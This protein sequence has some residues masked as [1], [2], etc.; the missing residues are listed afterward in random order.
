MKHEESIRSMATQHVPKLPVDQ[1]RFRRNLQVTKSARQ[2]FHQ[3][4]EMMVGDGVVLLPAFIGWSA[5]EGSGV[6]DPVT[7]LNLKYKFYA[8]N[9]RLR[10]DVEDLESKLSEGNV[11]VL[12]LIH[13]FGYVDPQAASAAAAARARGIWVIEDSAH[14][15]FSDWVGGTCGHFGQASIYSFHKMLPVNGGGGFTIHGDHQHYITTD[16]ARPATQP[17]SDFDLR[18]IA[19]KRL[20]NARQIDQRIRHM[21]P[22]LAPL[23]GMPAP[24]QF[25]Q[26][27]PVLIRGKCRDSL[28]AEMNAAGYGVVSLYHTMIESIGH[29]QFPLA[30]QVAQQIMNLPVHQ[31]L[32]PCQIDSMLDHLEG[33]VC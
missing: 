25:P 11:S 10:I 4:L 5:R 7:E 32:E 24:G 8:L 19:Y 29:G 18:G 33:L 26:T 20:E 15:L 31:D 17:W 12:L 9:E 21:H 16:D 14:A 1:T 27:Y 3:L 13:Y 23:W 2:G 22:M 6:F 28:Y 30:R